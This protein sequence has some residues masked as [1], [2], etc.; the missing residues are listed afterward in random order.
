MPARRRVANPL[1]LAV[2]TL[3]QERAMH[4]YEMVTTLRERGKED[5][6]N[7]KYGSLYSV[8]RALLREGLIREVETVRVGRHP[9]RTIY[10]LTEAGAQETRTWLRE[11]LGDLEHEFPQ[12]LAGLSLMPALPVDEAVELLEQRADRVAERIGRYE[13]RMAEATGQGVDEIFLV[14]DDYRLALDRVELE[15]VRRLVAG[16][17]DESIT[18]VRWWRKYHEERKKGT[19]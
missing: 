3:L 1:A 2:L 8:V 19:P 11:L 12:F 10:E 5:S 6:I 18:G 14:E 17:R 7:I 15:W 4:P 9:E 16:L 13:S